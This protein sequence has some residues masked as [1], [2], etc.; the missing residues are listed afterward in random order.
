MIKL[1]KKE[2]ILNQGGKISRME[3]Y[4]GGRDIR[5]KNHQGVQTA[6]V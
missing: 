5:K 4:L 2:N 6:M 1:R 3:T